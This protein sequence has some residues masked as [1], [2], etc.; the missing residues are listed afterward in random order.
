MSIS[1]K[2][3]FERRLGLF[4][5]FFDKDG[6]F[7]TYT[8]FGDFSH[9]IPQKRMKGPDDYQPTG[10][11][12]SYKKPVEVSSSLPD[13]PKENATDEDIRKYWSAETG[14]K[15]EWIMIDLQN[16]C[17]VNAI[18]IN[19]FDEST[20]ILGRND[21]IYYQY[22]LEYSIDKK[23][24]KALVDKRMNKIDMPH[25]Y[26]ELQVPVN[27]R[28]VRVT[29]YHVPDGKFAIS[30]L[31]V[32]GKG[33]GKLPQEVQSLTVLRD[34][35]DT[36]NVTLS[37]NNTSSAVGY[38]IRYGTGPDKLYLNYQV[39]GTNSLTIRSLNKLKTYYFSIDAFNENGITKGGKI[40]G[41]ELLSDNKHKLKK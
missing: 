27:A 30:E 28:Y 7:Y 2:H 29:N 11:L 34:T 36:R 20:T 12:L 19:Y 24:W 15:G 4:P 21:S 31:R 8:G 6:T 22:L 40:V 33:N 13:H 9:S 41:T 10:M 32:F 38:N 25:D 18:Q 17:I 1:V 26:V 14:N 16:Q 5:A 37:W 3:R 39:L 35:T 23:I